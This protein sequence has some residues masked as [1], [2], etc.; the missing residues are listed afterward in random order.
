MLKQ[1]RDVVWTFSD[2][3]AS[4]SGLCIHRARYKKV[5]DTAWTWITPVNTDSEGRDFA[6]VMLP[7]GSL[8]A[9]TYQ[10]YFDVRDC[11]GQLTGVPKLYYF[12]VPAP[13]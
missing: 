5:E 8:P 13:Q 6:Y 11:A 3:Y 7:A 1:N 4:C 12:K 10:F 9:G 2:D